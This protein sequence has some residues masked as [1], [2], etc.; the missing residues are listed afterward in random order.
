VEDFKD[1]KII[2]KAVYWGTHKRDEI[3]LLILKL[4]NTM[5]NFR[6]STYSSSVEFL[7]KDEKDLIINATP[8]IEHLNDGRQKNIA[9]KKNSSSTYKL[10]IWNN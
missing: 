6:L 4:S 10:C 1:F 5:N 3:K 8:T 2:C 9:T 7:S